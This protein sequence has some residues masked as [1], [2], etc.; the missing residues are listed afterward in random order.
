MLSKA[1]HKVIQ[2]VKCYPHLHD[3]TQNCLKLYRQPEA[4]PR[5]YKA[6]QLYIKPYK[7]Y[8]AILSCMMLYQISQIN[9]AEHE[10]LAL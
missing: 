9:L 8:K 7:A 2:V 1:V 6:A 3:T 10:M 4:V 5:P